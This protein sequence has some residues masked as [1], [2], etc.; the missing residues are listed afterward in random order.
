V[1]APLTYNGNIYL[2]SD[3][4]LGMKGKLTSEEREKLICQWLHSIKDDAGAIILVGDIFDYWFEY[5]Q[6]VPK[7]FSRFWAT[8]RILRDQGIPIVFF[9][10]NHDMWMFK[11]ATEEYGI[12]IFSDPQEF[13][14]NGKKVL[15]HHGD[16]LGP[17][18]YGYKFIK[19]FT[20]SKICQWI[21]AR[22]HPNF[23]LGVM[24]FFSSTSRNFDKEISFDES[25]ERLIPYCEDQIKKT[26]YDY[27]IFGHRHLVI[28]HVLSN[29]KSRYIN[30]GDWLNDTS[31]LKMTENDY[32]LQKYE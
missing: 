16:G 19:Q 27:L 31:F 30:L 23:A 21:F 13:L 32:K 1:S 22:L 2:A 7:G 11:Y 28:D 12:P 6:V 4:H 26:A 5:K 8:M 3:F 25:T 14:L 24:R 29:G 18:D 9:T 17:G 10:G 15:I 20:S